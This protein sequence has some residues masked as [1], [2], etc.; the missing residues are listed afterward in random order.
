MASRQLKG[1]ALTPDEYMEILYVGRAAEHDFLVFKSLANEKLALST[2]DPMPKIADVA[3]GGQVP[4]LHAAVGLP[5]ELDLVVPY[6]GRRQVVKGPVYAYHELVSQ[7]PMT[8]AEWRQRVAREPLA[9]W[10]APFAV[11]AKLTCPAKPPF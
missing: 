7:K 8:D 1:E 9:P 5:L 10:I 4:I 3:G 11:D 2:P 6:F